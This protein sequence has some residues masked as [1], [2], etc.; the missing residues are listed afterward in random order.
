[1][2]ALVISIVVSM[3]IVLVMTPFLIKYLQKKQLGQFIRVDGPKSHQTK[4]GTPTMGGLVVI[5]AA[6]CGYSSSA[7]WMYISQGRIPKI[8]S[9]LVLSLMFLMG[10]VGLYDDW[11]KISKKQSLGLTPLQ[12]FVAQA[13]IGVVFAVLSQMFPDYHGVSPANH[14]ITFINTIF[15]FDFAG[16]TLGFIL[17]VVWVNLIITAWTNAVNLTDGL[18][19]LATGVSVFAWVGYIIICSWQFAHSC[20]HTTSALEGICYSVRDPWDLALV[21]GGIMGACFGFLW[22]NAYPAK[23]FMGDTGSL[24]LGGAFAAMSILTHTQILAI[25]IGGVFVL[26]TLSVTLQVGSFKMFK[27]RIFKMAPLHHHFEL[28]GW[29]EINVVIRFWLIA[30]I[31]MVIGIGLFYSD[32]VGW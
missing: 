21:A 6:L 1:M 17:F 7:F 16:K 9:V 31:C 5:V 22:Y 29:K 28:L 4:R 12:K 14:D 18:D 13:V 10:A 23:I 3:V 24:A 27:K 11:S 8:S 15:S 20:L 32:W 2:I 19:G 25:I 26:E 30:G